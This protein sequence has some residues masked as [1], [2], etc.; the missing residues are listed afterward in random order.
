MKGVKLGKSLNSSA[1]A[2]FK[3]IYICMYVCASALVIA[4]NRLMLC[5]L[6]N[7]TTHVKILITIYNI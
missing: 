7:N 6:Y 1:E 5:C 4:C 2:S 3:I